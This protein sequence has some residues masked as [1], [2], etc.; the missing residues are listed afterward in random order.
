ML[1]RATPILPLTWVLVHPLQCILAYHLMVLLYST[2]HLYLPMM[3]HFL[4]DQHIITTTAAGFLQAVPIDPCTYL[5]LHLIQVDLWWEIVC[6]ISS[7]LTFVCDF[8]NKEP[9]FHWE[10]HRKRHPTQEVHKPT[11]MVSIPKEQLLHIICSHLFVVLIYYII[12]F[13]L[14]WTSFFMSSTSTLW[15]VHAVVIDLLFIYL[16]C[17]LVF[18]GAVYGMPPIMDRYGMALPMGPGTMVGHL[19]VNYYPVAQQLFFPEF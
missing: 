10:G 17:F 6:S 16:F 19:I 11:K 3:C 1:H 13:S 12:L 2:V 7:L 14:C 18:I 9:N 4:G 5:G 8:F 15:E